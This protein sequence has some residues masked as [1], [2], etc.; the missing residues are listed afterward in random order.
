VKNPKVLLGVGAISALSS[1]VDPYAMPPP[2][3][4][5]P[6][7]GASMPI[8][9]YRQRQLAYAESLALQRERALMR[10]SNN[11]A[12]VVQST[13][14]FMVNAATRTARSNLVRQTRNWTNDLFGNSGGGGGLY[15]DSSSAS[16]GGRRGPAYFPEYR[17]SA[18]PSNS[19]ARN[20]SSNN[21][22]SFA[23]PKS[24]GSRSFGPYTSSS[25][26]K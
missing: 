15:H 4:N 10:L 19:G 7:A 3:Y 23:Q 17:S 20:F 21:Y 18:P 22:R 9:P 2:A 25:Y 8:D 5:S 24:G 13:P 12:F 1:C 6:L 11:N 26:R 14:G 16:T